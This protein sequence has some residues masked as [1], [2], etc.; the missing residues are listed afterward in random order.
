LSGTGVPLSPNPVT[1]FGI[2]KDADEIEQARQA[3]QDA[4]LA[5]HGDNDAPQ[6]RVLEGVVKFNKDGTKILETGIDAATFF[7]PGPEEAITGAIAAKLLEKGLAVTFKGAKWIF[8]GTG[9]KKL[10]KEAEQEAVRLAQQIYKEEKAAA[11]AVVEA[12]KVMSRPNLL[13]NLSKGGFEDKISAARALTREAQAI[14]PKFIAQEARSVKGDFLFIGGGPAPG[15]K[16]VLIIRP[17]GSVFRMEFDAAKIKSIVGGG[18]KIF[19]LDLTGAE[20][21]VQKG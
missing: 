12:R 3:Q 7:L 16:N 20:E 10:T 5:P 17:D 13:S 4:A 19:D 21:L 15:Q 6:Q 18:S 9:G 11:E 2:F 14:N 8:K 1:G